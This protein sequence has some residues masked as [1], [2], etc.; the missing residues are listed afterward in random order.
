VHLVKVKVNLKVKL[1]LEEGMKA[2]R[3]SRGLSLT[4]ALDGGGWSRL[5]YAPGE[6]LV[7]VVLEA[8]WVPG[9]VWMG[10]E[11]LAPI[12]ILSLDCPV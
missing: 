4:L 1:I 10:V 7:P 11:N 8:G 5:L 3:G 9:P 12:G 2:Q 6:D